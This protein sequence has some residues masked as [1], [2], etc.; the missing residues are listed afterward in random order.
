MPRRPITHLL[1]SVEA[2]GTELG[3]KASLLSDSIL[4]IYQTLMSLPGKVEAQ[5][6]SEQPNVTVS[7]ERFREWG[8]WLWDSDTETE[9]PDELITVSISRKA[10]AFPV[11]LDLLSA[12]DREM[13][14]QI[15]SIDNAIALTGKYVSLPT[16]GQS[17]E[18]N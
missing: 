2:A 10:R 12:I 11:L 13:Q 16:V 1:K 7:F 17:K 4:K 6:R 18:A 9:S 8:L 14:S 15:K 3:E 5:V